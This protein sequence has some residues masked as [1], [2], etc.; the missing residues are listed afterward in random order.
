MAL[1]N[2]V[3]PIADWQRT[4]TEKTLS[5]EAH[6]EAV[7]RYARGA[8]ARARQ[9][10]AALLASVFGGRRRQKVTVTVD[11]REG[12]PLESVRPAGGRIVADFHLIDDLLSF[13]WLTLRDRSPVVSGAY[14]EGHT[15]LAD[16]RPVAVGVN[17]VA[18]PSATEYVFT[19][20]VPYARKIEVGRTRS[21]R[22]FVIQV[23]NRIYERTAA[24]AARQFGN[25]ADIAFAFRPAR[26]VGTRIPAI[27]IR[28]R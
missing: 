28:P 24:D 15:L 13:L 12:A 2:A 21:G 16:G 4:V 8:I 11:G 23:P 27:I 7:A 14:R 18:V 1:R 26:G 19:N 6:A 17:S 20:V 9:T 5:E 22:S 3:E 10:N 25:I